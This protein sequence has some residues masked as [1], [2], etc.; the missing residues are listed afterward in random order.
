MMNAP[1]RLW[2]AASGKLIASFG[3]PQSF[4]VLYVAFS[5]DGARNHPA[6]I[7][8]NARLW[9]AASGKLIASFDLGPAWPGTAF[10]EADRPALHFSPHSARVLAASADHT[11][12][13][14]DAASG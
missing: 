10:L 6:S 12:K 7:D 13:L 1:V 8:N 3:D 5:P 9:D 14:W 4:D 11:A 2:D